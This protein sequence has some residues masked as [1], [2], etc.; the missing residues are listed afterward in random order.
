MDYEHGASNRDC[1]TGQ[2]SGTWL[3][4]C[5]LD[6]VVMRDRLDFDDGCSRGNV[7]ARASNVVAS[8]ILELDADRVLGISPGGTGVGN[9]ALY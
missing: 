5:L 1:R 2:A 7:V 4:G 9:G 8:A 6:H 3:L